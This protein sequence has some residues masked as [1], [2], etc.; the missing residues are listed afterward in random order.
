LFER[1]D[2]F[3]LETHVHDDHV[4]ANADHEAR[5]DHAGFDFLVSDALFEELGKTFSH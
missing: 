3:R 2:R 5:E 4:V 1:D